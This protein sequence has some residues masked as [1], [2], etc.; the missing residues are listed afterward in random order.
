VNQYRVS[1]WIENQGDIPDKYLQL[2]TNI[3]SE[4]EDVVM[5]AMFLA[6]YEWVREVHVE[7]FR[8]GIWFR[9][10]ART[11]VSLVGLEFEEAYLY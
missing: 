6:R 4:F 8:G 9:A 3:V 7:L 10:Y 1:L 11:N 5:S 2:Q